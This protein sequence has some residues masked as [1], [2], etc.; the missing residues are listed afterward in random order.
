MYEIKT[1]LKKNRLYITL[2]EKRRAR[3]EQVL[4]HIETACRQLISGFTCVAGFSK[5]HI[6][7]AQTEDL[8]QKVQDILLKYGVSRLVRVKKEV[9]EG[10]RLQ[11][12][13]LGI[14]HGY[15]ITYASNIRQ[16]EKILDQDL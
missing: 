11:M 12:E 16:A 6:A 3:I 13:M 2:N 14:K 15:P 4:P 9:R 8:F 1:D 5:N 10:E 7:R